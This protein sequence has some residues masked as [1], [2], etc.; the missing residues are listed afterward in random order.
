MLLPYADAA[1]PRQTA[2]NAQAARSAIGVP[3]LVSLKFAGKTPPNLTPGRVRLRESSGRS[4][5]APHLF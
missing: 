5:D 1:L 2:G 3:V 4:A